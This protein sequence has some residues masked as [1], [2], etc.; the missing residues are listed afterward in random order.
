M[1]LI[2][3]ARGRAPVLRLAP[4][5]LLALFSMGADG[6][7]TILLTVNQDAA[8]SASPILTGVGPDAGLSV[9]DASIG[10]VIPDGGSDGT[11]IDGAILDGAV[12][13]DAD[14]QAPLDA[15]AAFCPANLDAGAGG[16]TSG[17]PQLDDAGTSIATECSSMACGPSPALDA[18]PGD[19]PLT[20]AAYCANDATSGACSWAL[21]CSY[22]AIP[23]CT[24]NLD[25]NSGQFCDHPGLDSCD[26][27]L[28]SCKDRPSLCDQG[29]QPVCG[30]DGVSYEN[31][32]QANLAGISVHLYACCE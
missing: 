10:W 12:H 9:P 26:A 8:V 25:C 23:S 7:D 21:R 16:S 15:S 22:A 24:T 30:C 32:C 1:P 6:C 13:L 5:T 19:Q 18:C 2:I 29:G 11:V 28:G 14:L 4:L 3:S 20:I 27:A 31:E 17:F